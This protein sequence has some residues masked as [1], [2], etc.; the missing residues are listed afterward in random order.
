MW[1]P[2]V[3]FEY[4]TLFDKLMLATV[5]EQNHIE[6]SQLLNFNVL[7][8]IF[9]FWKM[10]YPPQDYD[11]NFSMVHQFVTKSSNAYFIHFFAL[12]LRVDIKP[13]YPE[14]SLNGR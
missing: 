5:F 9:T 12:F 13:Q 1:H 7:A 11:L 14:L 6:H 10:T 3:C 2:Q 8:F 4:G